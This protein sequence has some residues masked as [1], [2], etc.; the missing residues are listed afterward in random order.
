MFIGY[1]LLVIELIVGGVVGLRFAGF[2]NLSPITFNHFQLRY[3]V[4]AYGGRIK[5]CFQTICI[6]WKRF[7][8][9]LVSWKR[10]GCRC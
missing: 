6:H 1:C 9:F 3:K 10:K 7:P 8:A 2:Y 4:T 5:I